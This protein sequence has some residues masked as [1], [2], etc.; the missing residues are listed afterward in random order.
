[1]PRISPITIGLLS[2]VL[3]LGACAGPYTGP[4]EVTRFVSPDRGALGQ[5]TIR[6]A[7]A[8]GATEDLARAA[9]S[10]AVSEEL[11]R[12]GYTVV[13]AGS[14]SQQ[15]ATIRTTRQQFSA[16]QMGGRSPVSVGVGGGG[17]SF[18]GGG[19]G[20]FGGGV[21]I[22]LGG[23]QRGPNV[24]TE[25]FVRIDNAAGQ[26]LWEGRAQMATGVRSRYS[27]LALSAQTLA[28]GLFRDFPG[29][30]GETV[31]IKASELKPT[32]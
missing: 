27:E 12:I 15:V 16:G 10:Q 19:F 17:G 28:G 24:N 26:S 21:G 5:G 4:V 30:N 18:G 7:I 6:V 32:L 22:N 23:G 1:M 2:G 9:Y 14:T 11:R 13:P 8:D 3:A 20:G 29:G 25:L 31:T